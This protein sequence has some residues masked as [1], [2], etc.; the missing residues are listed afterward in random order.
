MEIPGEINI[1]A[2]KKSYFW[3]RML[4]LIVFLYFHYF[5]DPTDCFLLSSV[6]LGCAVVGEDCWSI[7]ILQKFSN[8][9]KLKFFHI[10]VKIFIN[11]S[12]PYP[13]FPQIKQKNQFVQTSTPFHLASECK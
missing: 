3:Q 8:K 12:S 10:N 2:K 4:D 13:Q 5:L 11:Y 9:N 7:K 6:F 1:E